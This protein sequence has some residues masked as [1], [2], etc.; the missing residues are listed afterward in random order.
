MIETASKLFVNDC[1]IK[2]ASVVRQLEENTT[3]VLASSYVRSLVAQGKKVAH[4]DRSPSESYL[5]LLDRL[6]NAQEFAYKLLYTGDLVSAI[7]FHDKTM[8]SDRP[9]ELSVL[10]SDVTYRLCNP[11]AGF[12]KWSF[13][14]VLTA[15]RDIKMLT[16]TAIQHED[17]ATFCHEFGFLLSIYPE[18]KSKRFV[19]I[20]DGDQAKWAAARD[21]FEKVILILCIYHSRENM[22]KRFGPLCRSKPSVAG[23]SIAEPFDDATRSLWIQCELEC[24]QKWRRLPIGISPPESYH[25]GQGG[26]LGD[27]SDCTQPEEE[28]ESNEASVGSLD[29]D[30]IQ[31]YQINPTNLSWYALW[32]G[33]AHLYHDYQ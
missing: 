19:L 15:E 24:C 12:P 29:C 26:W 25:C 17:R 18:L 5:E 6:D 28:L 16:A 1:S 11:T 13:V 4:G 3:S 21:S 31:A 10:V 7:S 2:T 23:A 33:E 20:L 8:H 27:T 32:K 30:I 9:L 22:K 14:S